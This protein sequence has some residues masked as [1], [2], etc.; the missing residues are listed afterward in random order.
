[1]LNHIGMVS[2]L[3]VAFWYAIL[4]E[5]RSQLLIGFKGG[6]CSFALGWQDWFQ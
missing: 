5:F 3:A 6:V 4:L 2:G 1:V